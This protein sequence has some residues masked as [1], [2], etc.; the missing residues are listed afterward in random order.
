MLSKQALTIKLG[1]GVDTKTDAKS[2]PPGKLTRLENVVFTKNF[3]LSKRPG[4]D[5]LSTVTIAGAEIETPDGLAT[6]NDEL[7]LYANQNLYSRSPGSSAWVDKGSVVSAIVKTSQIVKNT[8]QQTQVDSNVN[9]SISVYAWEDSRGGVRASV[10][11]EATG[12]PIIVDTSLDASASRVRCV[13]FKSYLYVFYYK[14]GSLYGR[15]LNPARPTAFDAAVE[16]SNS[17]NTTSPTYDVINYRDVR[18]C[19]VHNVQGAS[20]IDIGWLDDALAVQTGALA[21]KTIAEAGTNCLSVFIGPSNNLWVCYQNNTDGVRCSVRNAGGTEVV[22]PLTV[23]NITASNVINITGHTL[24]AS[25]VRI[26]YEVDAAS[27]FNQ[28]VRRNDVTTAGSAGTAADFMRS[29]GLWSKVFLFTDRDDND[30]YF[31]NLIH[32]STLQATYFTARSDGLLVARYQSTTAGTHTTRPLLVNVWERQASK[33]EWAILNKT[34]IVSENATIYTPLGVSKT[35][36]DFANND[37]FTAKQLGNNLHVCGGFLSMYDGQS[38]V[39]HG[40]HLFPENITLTPQT[41]GGSLADGSYQVVIVYEWTDNKGQLHRSSP[42]VAQTAIV[43]GGGGSGS[44]DVVAPALRLT[45]KKSPRSNVSIVGYVTEASGTVFYRYTSVT[46]PTYNDPT[47]D[48]VTMPDVTTVSTS[49]EI[50]YTTGGV[51]ENSY[52]PACS[53]IEVYKGR[54]W[55][56]GLE[57]DSLWYSKE[58][59]VNDPVEFS[60]SLTLAIESIGGPVTGISVLDDKLLLLKNDRYYYTFGD[61]PNNLGLDGAFAEPLF[62]TADVGC[63]NA[64]SLSRIPGGVVFKSR[65]GIYAVDSTLNPV[66]I[67]ADVESFNSLT[68]TSASLVAAANQVRF[69][70]ESGPT[71][72]FDYFQK[73]WSTFTGQGAYDSVLWQNQYTFL[74]TSGVVFVENLSSFKDNVSPVRMLIETGWISLAGLAGFKRVYK[75]MLIGSYKSRHKLRVSCA[76]DFSDAYTEVAWFDPASLLGISTYGEDS[77][78]GETGTVYGGSNSAYRFTIFPKKQKCQA[79]KILIEEDTTT[80][81]AGSQEGFTLAAIGLEVGMK[82]GFAKL[83]N[84]QD[85]ASDGSF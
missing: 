56:A 29:V 70:T 1:Q 25:S 37:I 49:N 33:F 21:I 5:D 6:F 8:A 68:V 17:V 30:F 11:D 67:G 57:D 81:T 62:V 44:I 50:L 35:S 75:I 80:A 16:I 31:V 51:L 54:L 48:T 14:S 46:S 18:M 45:A 15:R 36:L 79:I 76:F 63:E 84:S 85:V 72:V 65:K 24:T 42:S 83:N 43:S 27:T 19:F 64:V 61:G 3:E 55:L 32:Q 73:Q 69:T 58:M 82:Q 20:E 78:Y 40:F 66:Y 47:A 28:V 52:S 53:A 71:L 41:T 13:S 12:T 22:A 38:V 2:L 77:P 74:K 34:Q 26:Y 10:Y 23:E 59:R 4:Y 39:E 7:L 60:T 9:G